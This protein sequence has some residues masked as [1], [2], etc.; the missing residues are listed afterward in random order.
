MQKRE[1]ATARQWY[2]KIP[3]TRHE[4]NNRTDGLEY[5]T[6]RSLV[7]RKMMHLFLMGMLCGVIIMAAV[8]VVFAIPANNFHWQM[9]IFNRGGAAWMVDKNG[10]TGWKWMV[11]PVRDTPL[12]KRVMSPPSAVKVR[13]EQL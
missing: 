13:S 6:E 3:Q 9:E 2:G 12:Q 10:R 5:K 7:T 4:Q 8:T 11:D 1:L